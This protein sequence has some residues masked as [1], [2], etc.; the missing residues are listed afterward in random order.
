MKAMSSSPV[1]EALIFF[2]GTHDVNWFSTNCGQTIQAMN[3]GRPVDEI[4]WHPVQRDWLL[5]AAWNKC[6]DFQID[7][8][9]EVNY[10]E[11]RF[12]KK[13]FSL[14]IWDKNGSY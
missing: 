7:E 11:L 3:T 2:Q 5:V 1:D 13:S 8:E 14:I 4:V 9:C 12:T 6:E 10:I